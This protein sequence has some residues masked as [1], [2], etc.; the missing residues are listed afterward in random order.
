M[1]E[2]RTRSQARVNAR[3]QFSRYAC[4]R[5]WGGVVAAGCSALVQAVLS[6]LAHL[7]RL[8]LRILTSNNIFLSYTTVLL[9]DTDV[10]LLK[11]APGNPTQI[12]EPVSTLEARNVT[13]PSRKLQY[14]GIC[15]SGNALAIA[16]VNDCCWFRIV[17]SLSREVKRR[18]GPR[19]T[20]NDP[21]AKS[22]THVSSGF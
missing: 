1:Y 9:K 21:G 7:R 14:L 8:Y 13:H 22:N 19:A 18:E 12:Q 17:N 5:V 16:A 6:V 11:I 4:L 3:S 10:E 20:S 2:A 15:V